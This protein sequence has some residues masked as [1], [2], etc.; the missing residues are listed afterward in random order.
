MKSRMA[1]QCVAIIFLLAVL[2]A[3]FYFIFWLAAKELW[4]TKVFP[5]VDC[6]SIDDTYGDMLETYAWYDSEFINQNDGSRSSGCLQ[7]FCVQQFNQYGITEASS[8][9]FG[10]E[11]QPF[12]EDFFKDILKAKL[13]KNGISYFISIFN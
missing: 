3:S 1:R 7:C 8:M 9:P 4:V 2:C 11:Q 6:Q 10:P 12:C 5:V 13:T